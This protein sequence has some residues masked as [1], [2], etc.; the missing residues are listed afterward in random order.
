MALHEG[1][2]HP[3]RG[4]A[5]G[6]DVEALTRWRVRIEGVGKKVTGVARAKRGGEDG[7]EIGAKVQ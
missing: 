6:D 1:V 2:S 5:G 4:L 7:V 3:L